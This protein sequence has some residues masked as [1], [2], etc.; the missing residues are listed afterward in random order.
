MQDTLKRYFSF[1][2]GFAKFASHQSGP[3]RKGLPRHRRQARR[4]F[5]I[6]SDIETGTDSG[7]GGGS[8]AG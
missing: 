7:Q 2:F 6:D 4:A 5:E 3:A 8:D 1:L